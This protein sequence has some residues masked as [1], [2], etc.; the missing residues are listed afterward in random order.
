MKTKQGYH[1]VRKMMSTD[2]L[3]SAD[4]VQQWVVT[5]ACNNWMVKERVERRSWKDIII[6]YIDV[7][8]VVL[9]NLVFI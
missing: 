7:K 9:T 1:D 2:G 8:K 5:A 6:V 4:E 3:A